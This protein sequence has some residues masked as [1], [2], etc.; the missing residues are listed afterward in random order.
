[1]L[2]V[3]STAPG[4]GVMTGGLAGDGVPGV[5][6]TPGVL[7]VLGVG[8]V[9]GV[10]GVTGVAGEIGVVVSASVPASL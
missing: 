3:I 5:T 10:L 7:G 1:M 6:M 8:G 9:T 4:R 2:V